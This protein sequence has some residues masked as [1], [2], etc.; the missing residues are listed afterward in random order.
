MM[1]SL[2][3]NDRRRWAALGALCT[4]LVVVTIDNT[5]L[6]TAIPT[7]ARELQATTV[8]LQWI[9][10]A[11]T[12]AFAAL[13]ITAGGLGTRFGHRRILLTGLTLFA[14]GSAFAALSHTSLQ[15]IGWRTMMGA[16]A[17]LVMPATLSLAVSM[18]AP[19]ERG[20]AIGIWSA[21]AG[22]GITIGP[23]VGGV[24]LEHFSWGSVFWINVPLV[25]VVIA[26][27]VSLVPSAGGMV[28][29]SFDIPGLL[30]SAGGLALIVDALTQASLRRWSS[31]I[32]V[33]EIVSATALLA[34]FVWW[35]LRVPAPM[36]DVRI[37]TSRV[38]SISN[39]I[40]AATF[41]A[42]FGVLFTYTQYLQF[43][44]GYGPLVAGVGAVPFALVMA[45]VASSS[46]RVVGRF[47]VRS[48]IAGGLTVMSVGLLVLSIAAGRYAPFGVLAA[49][50]ALVGAGMGLVMAPATTAS[51]SSVTPQQA[52]MAS[53]INSV[54]R[55]L[56]GVLGV[57]IVGTVVATVFRSRFEPGVSA[58]TVDLAQI[59]A[60][61]PPVSIVAE[62]A[63]QAYTS[64]MCMGIQICAAAAFLG[65]LAVIALFPAPRRPASCP[66]ADPANSD[67]V[68][69][70]SSS[71]P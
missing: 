68:D 6:N 57:A 48:S 49:I 19:H 35:E 5:I 56:G 52:S 27:T 25:A 4:S 58:S 26:A 32:T 1:N 47:G 12:L 29:G 66:P 59:H 7:L 46:H 15:L 70:R 11:Y 37:F 20:R 14:L 54:V 63:N 17:A 2:E 18:F 9:T 53:S 31:P 21:T 42:L 69:A 24:L 39:A 45:A 10:N 51:M 30:L 34:G 62:A 44:R 61:A 28:K 55:E 22:L 71:N 67:D 16:A 8:D 13:L 41:F 50:M 23:V 33:L 60:D 36:T 40:L 38:F 43:V 65:A 3:P 64:A